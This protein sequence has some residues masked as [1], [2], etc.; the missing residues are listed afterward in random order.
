MRI[1]TIISILLC[2]Y[3]FASCRSTSSITTKE[4]QIISS[5]ISEEVRSELQIVKR[6]IDAKS[7]TIVDVRTPEEFAEGHIKNS[8]NIPLD[9][10]ADSLE[11]FK[12][13]KNIVVVCGSGK[14]AAKGKAI[15]NENGFNN[16]YNGMGWAELDKLLK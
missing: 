1:I 6:L 3:L 4:E 2:A 16:V 7:A 9:T 10:I 15:L 14:R 13:Y 11:V 5:S 12:Q 8:I